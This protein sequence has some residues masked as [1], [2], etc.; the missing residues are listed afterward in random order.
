MKRRTKTGKRKAAPKRRTE[1]VFFKAEQAAIRN[2]GDVEMLNAA[3][4]KDVERV[5][6]FYADDASMFPPN[7]PIATGKEAIRTVCSPIFANPGFTI[8]WHKTKVGLSRAGDLAY[9]TGTYEVTTHD[10]QGNPVTD[11]GKDVT[12]WKKQ[13]DRSWKIVADIW[14]SDRPLPAPPKPNGTPESTDS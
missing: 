9:A 13:A 8:N 6:S 7:A 4:E 14:N 11:R 10:P 12:V 2:A 1:Q 3:R 5:L